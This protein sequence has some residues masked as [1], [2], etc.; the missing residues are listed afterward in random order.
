MGSLLRP[1]LPLSLKPRQRLLLIPTTMV[2]TDM[3]SV[4][5]LTDTD[6]VATTVATV[7]TTARGR[8]RL[9]PT[10]TATDLDT[11]VDT[12]E[13]T[14]LSATTVSATG[15]TTARGRL[16]LSPRLRLR[17]SPTTTVATTAMDSATTVS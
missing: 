5:G 2:D 11:T 3:D 17:L 6:S 13:D 14:A 15:S 1:S 4:L 10:C 7:A 16:R 12:S 8:L 9:S